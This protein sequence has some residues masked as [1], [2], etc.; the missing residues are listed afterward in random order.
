M[1][2]VGGRLSSRV[3]D[4]ICPLE[5]YQPRVEEKWFPRR[6]WGWF[7]QN[8][9]GWV[10]SM[11]ICLL[12]FS[13][14]YSSFLLPKSKL[15][16]ITELQS[17]KWLWSSS[18]PANFKE[19]IWKLV[20]KLSLGPDILLPE[21]FFKNNFHIGNPNWSSN[22]LRKLCKCY[23]P[24]LFSFHCSPVRI[25]DQGDW[26]FQHFQDVPCPFWLWYLLFSHCNELF[27]FF[28]CDGTWY[29]KYQLYFFI[30]R[31]WG[32]FF[33]LFHCE[34]WSIRK[35]YIRSPYII[36]HLLSSAPLCFIF[37]HCF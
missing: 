27:F 14:N 31:H 37:F 15:R 28:F 21:A 9:K 36:V 32:V 6:K 30:S 25:L 18:C 13:K 12:Y 7:H 33:F 3:R 19:I 23:L 5:L 1:A 26:L 8:V 35:I 24:S 2:R 29:P 4:A 16:N 11:I 20:T 10:L 17:W 34:N 22:T